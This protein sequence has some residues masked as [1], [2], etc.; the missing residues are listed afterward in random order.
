MGEIFLSKVLPLDSDKG[1]SK[2]VESAASKICRGQNFNK[3]LATPLVKILVRL[4]A[5]Q[6]QLSV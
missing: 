4:G 5:M 1:T 2:F 3:I 6:K